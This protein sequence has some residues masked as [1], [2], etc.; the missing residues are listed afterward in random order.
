MLWLHDFFE[1]CWSASALITPCV[2]D[3]KEIWERILQNQGVIRRWRGA[4]PETRGKPGGGAWFHSNG[5]RSRE[6]PRCNSNVDLSFQTSLP[7]VTLIQEFRTLKHPL[8]FQSHAGLHHRQ[9]CFRCDH[10]ESDTECRWPFVAQ[11]ES[12]ARHLGARSC[13]L[14]SSQGSCVLTELWSPS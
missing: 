12:V 2:T 11:R 13:P 5:T 9:W 10:L 7:K 8:L 3:R 14:P 4:S 6:I 1:V